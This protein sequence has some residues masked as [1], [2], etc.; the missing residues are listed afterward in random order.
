M[1]NFHEFLW[2][3]TN[4]FVKNVISTEDHTYKELKTLIHNKDVVILKGDKDWSIVIINKTDFIKKIETMIQ[5]GIKNGTYAE[6]DDT[7]MQD[8]IRFQC[9]L[10]WNFKKYEHYNEMYPESNEP[11]KIYGT[12]K[13]HKFGS[14]DNIEL[15]K[16][17]FCPIIDQTGTLLIK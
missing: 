5:K 8:L 9:F 11:A 14:K 6:T 10:C 12:A 1:G 3:Y 13:T 2:G 7:A 16:L 15:R 4:I 17:K